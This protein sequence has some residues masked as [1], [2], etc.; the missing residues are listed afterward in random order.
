MIQVIEV[1]FKEPTTI[2]FIREIGR[3]IKLAPTSVKN[4]LNQL[5]K[6]NLIKI[7]T[8]K[9]FNGYVSNRENEEFLFLK[10]AYNLYSLYELKRNIEESVHP[11]AIVLFG[12]YSRG[13][14]VESSD[15][16]ILVLSTIKKEINLEVIEKKLSRTINIMTIEYL[17]KLDKN[18]REKIYNGIVLSGE[19]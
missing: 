16:D 17:D 14:D 10:K 9:P 12:S 6:S 15:I 13:E 5:E 2:H 19:I 1:F 8:S 4:I 18:I 11:R 7:K 3:K